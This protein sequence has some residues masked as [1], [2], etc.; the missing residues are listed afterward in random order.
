MVGACDDWG[1]GAGARRVNRRADSVVGEKVLGV[2][3]IRAGIAQV[4]ERLNRVF[5][6]ADAAVVI[7]VVPGGILMTADLVRQLTFDVELDVISCPHTPGQRHNASPIVYSQHVPIA[8]R[9]VIVV[10]DAIESGGTMR[11]LVDHLQALGPESLSV[12]TLLVKPGRAEIPVPQ[13]YGF[14]LDGDEALVGFGMPWRGRLR[15][16]PFVARLQPE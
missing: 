8:G 7:T 15:N 14:E 3:E 10:D 4:A 9:D 12:A 6:T 11:R 16:L 2:D 5:S 1:A 13:F